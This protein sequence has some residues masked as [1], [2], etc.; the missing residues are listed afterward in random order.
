VCVLSGRWLPPQLEELDRQS[1]AKLSDMSAAD[2]S[3]LLEA[4]KTY[5]YTPSEGWLQQFAGG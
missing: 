1:Q 3:L 5:G 4:F 2:V